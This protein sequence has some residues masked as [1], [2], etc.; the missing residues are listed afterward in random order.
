MK[1]LIKIHIGDLIQEGLLI[2]NLLLI[3]FQITKNLS[4]QIEPKEWICWFELY[5]MLVSAINYGSSVYAK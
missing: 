5:H 4:E 3:Y 2:W 1:Y